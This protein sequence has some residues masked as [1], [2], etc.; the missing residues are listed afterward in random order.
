MRV[1]ISDQMLTSGHALFENGQ[2]RDGYILHLDQH[3]DRL[4]GGIEKI[5][6]TEQMKRVEWGIKEKLR[7]II[8]ETVS[9]SGVRDG[10]F[11]YYLSGGMEGGETPNFYAIVEDGIPVKPINGCKDL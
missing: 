4:F 7:D 9:R 10:A 5:R 8:T 6:L 2:I 3:L 1:P 11:R